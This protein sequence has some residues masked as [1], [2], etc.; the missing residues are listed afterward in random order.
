[1]TPNISRILVPLDFSAYSDT[2]LRY[3]TTLASRLGA[4]LD[5][6]NVVESPVP[7]GSW[8]GEIYVPNMPELHENL[9]AEAQDRLDACRGTALA[10]SVPASATV[11][12]GHPAATIVEYANEQRSDLIVLGTHGRTGLAH[13]L[14]GSVAEKVLR[15]AP[16][17]VLTVRD[18]VW[19]TQAAVTERAA[20]VA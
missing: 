14:M 9:V 5:L 1:M 16:C 11:R 2:A 13:L 3:A 6:L 7:L 18:T 4:S 17:P 12:I 8:T 20:S 15:L 10:E 19:T